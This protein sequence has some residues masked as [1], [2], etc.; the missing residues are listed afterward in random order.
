MGPHCGQQ[1]QKG[2][3]GVRL[4]FKTADSS[5]LGYEAMKPCQLSWNLIFKFI[6]IFSNYMQN[7][8]KFVEF[9]LHQLSGPL[10]VLTEEDS[11][12]ISWATGKFRLSVRRVRK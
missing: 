12:C 9:F 4:N 10:F 6:L 7:I 3:S 1:I 5:V 11:S 8:V 2:K